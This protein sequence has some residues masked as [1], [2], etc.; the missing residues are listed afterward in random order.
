MSCTELH[1]LPNQSVCAERVVIS[2][3]YHATYKRGR[4]FALELPTCK[5]RTHLVLV[6]L[7]GHHFGRYWVGI[8]R[9]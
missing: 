8:E 4:S 6:I 3:I 2:D 7:L 1:T 9:D 5:T